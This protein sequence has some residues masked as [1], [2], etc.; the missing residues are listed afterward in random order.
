MSLMHASASYSFDPVPCV[1][2]S[3]SSSEQAAVDDDAQSRTAVAPTSSPSPIPVASRRRKASLVHPLQEGH[4]PVTA[5]PSP[6]RSPVCPGK[7]AP[8]MGVKAPLIKPSVRPLPVCTPQEPSFFSSCVER[9]EA[10][11][12]KSISAPIGTSR[13]GKHY[14]SSIEN[15]L[16]TFNAL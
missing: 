10:E 16:L 4:T 14:L 12:E 6:L 11:G 3:G 15:C 1:A 9:A 8:R 13:R 7:R 5:R 2:T